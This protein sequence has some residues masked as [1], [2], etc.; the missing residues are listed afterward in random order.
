MPDYQAIDP[1]AA[2]IVTASRT[3]QEQS[4][5]AASSTIIGKG[6]IERIGEPQRAD[7]NR[8]IHWS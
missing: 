6:T 5:S 7:L 4:D 1:P 8:E 2:I 3:E